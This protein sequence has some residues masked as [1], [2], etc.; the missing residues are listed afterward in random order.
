MKTI[1]YV[2]NKLSIYGYTPTSVETLGERLTKH[3]IVHSV[4]SKKK[5]ILRLGEMLWTIWRLRNQIDFL[6]IDTYS[7]IAFFYALF[8]S[9]LARALKISYIPLLHGGDLPV[10]L[11]RSP[12]LCK[13]LFGSSFKNITPSGYLKEALNKKGYSAYVIPNFVEINNYPFKER[14]E[15]RPRLLWVRSFHQVYN[16]EMAILV[17]SN[18]LKNFPDASLCMVGPDKD[19]SLEKVQQLAND[20]G[21]AENVHFTGKLPKEEWID[22]SKEYDIFINT[23]N[24]DNTPVSVIE[25]MAL[26]LSI[27]STNAGGLPWVINSRKE[28]LLVNV[29]DSKE[30]TKAIE[31]I[32]RQS[33]LAIELIRN[34]RQKVEHFDI[35]IVLMKWKELLEHPKQNS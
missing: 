5:Q 26:G 4:S 21:V 7:S 12:Y 24:F 17:L 34:A 3:F 10:R 1:L 31:K 23:T 35:N 20:L 19:G 6:I 28:G 2:G 33:D 29:N 13:L 22:L 16:P 14:E 15:I 27:V 25:A 30:M 18:L 9:Q 11:Q 32:L 8:C